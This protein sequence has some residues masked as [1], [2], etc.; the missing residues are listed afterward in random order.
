MSERGNQPKTYPRYPGYCSY[1]RQNYREAGP[2]AEGPDEVFICYRCVLA[3]KKLIEDEYR[4][5]GQEL[6]S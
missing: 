2:L 1:C 3:C 4:R 6:P 5:R